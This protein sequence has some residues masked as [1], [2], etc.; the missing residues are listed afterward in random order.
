MFNNRPNKAQKGRGAVSNPK[1][2]LDN[3]ERVPEGDGWW[4]LEDDLLGKFETQLRPDTSKTIISHNTSPDIPFDRS[5]NPY[6]GC[7]H[8]CVYCYA[9]PT[10]S[11]LGMSPGLDFETKI[12]FKENAA[13][14]L[15][16]ELRRQG[17]ECKP[18]ALGVNTDAYQPAEKELKITRSI[19]E[20]LSA[21]NHPVSIITKSS[22]ILNDLDILAPMGQKSL[23]HVMISVT[24][25]DPNLAR[26]MEPRA[27][28]PANR[29]A[30]L[31]M[32]NE[33][34][35][36]TGVLAS[37]MIPAINDNEL[38]AILEASAE[39]GAVQ[40]GYL[41][42]RLPFELK[43]LFRDW[44]RVHFPDRENR[45]LS[46]IRQCREGSLNTAGFGVRMR[47]TG[48][49]A[50]ILNKRYKLACRRLKLNQRD[51]KWDF[52]CSLFKPPLRVG[53]QMKLI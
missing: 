2:R 1:N 46:L 37:P 40:A 23:V 20:V 5:I 39:I 32:L 11:Y 45:V 41:L 3:E 43:Q 49:Y 30:T 16:R 42:L 48:P 36:P 19:L 4:K 9:R 38:E 53:D 50:E 15:E 34:G 10:H 28:R 47:G 52:N 21:Y 6:K 44:L 13:V 35:V 14:L 17:Y 18:I 26:S 24:T 27:S 25:L 7:E 12:F 31:K 33:A 51:E 8:G 29:L 22:R